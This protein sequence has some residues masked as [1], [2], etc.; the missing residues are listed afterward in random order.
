M[1]EE[2]LV[3]VDAIVQLDFDRELELRSFGK[4]K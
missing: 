1:I 4:L 2:D 3:R